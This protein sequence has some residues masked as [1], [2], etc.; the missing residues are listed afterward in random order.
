MANIVTSTMKTEVIYDE[1]KNNKYVI[2]KEWDK[3]KKS[4]L[5]IMKNAGVTGELIQDQT[6]MY[7]INN[8]VKHDYGSVVITNLYSTIKGKESKAYIQENLEIIKKYTKSVDDV[9]I[10]VGKGIK[11]N[12]EATER[13]NS[14]LEMLASVKANILEI[15]AE[16][17]RRGFHPIFAAIKNQ[18]KLVKYTFEEGK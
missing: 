4:A 12:K 17:G 11:T 15:E 8:L 3:S 9:I 10:A 1:K 18:W 5:I 16:N 14:V 13:L 7:V 2:K 6:T